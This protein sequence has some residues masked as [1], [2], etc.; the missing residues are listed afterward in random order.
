MQ[1][2]LY[3][4]DRP[5]TFAFAARLRS[6]TEQKPG[7]FLLAELASD[8]PESAIADYTAGNDRFHTAYSF[9]FLSKPFGP[10]VIRKGVE[11]LFARAPDA[12]PSWAFSNH[13]FDRVASRW[14]EGRGPDFAKSLIML[15]T[16]LPGTIF[17]YQGEELGL[18]QAEVPFEALRDP[19][20]IAFWPAYKGRDGE[21]TPIPWSESAPHGGFSDADPW[22]PIDPRHL[23]MAVDRQEADPHSTLTFTRDWLSFRRSRPVFTLPGIVFDDEAPGGVLGFS[24]GHGAL[25]LVF[26][27]GADAVEIP[28]QGARIVFGL[29]ATAANETIRLPAGAA[30][31]LEP[32]RETA[33]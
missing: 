21:R 16:S 15:L 1:R 20:G 26:N 24:R 13:D 11:D 25:R 8:D 18:P 2:H 12:W 32:S 17:L 31:A 29:S 5:E 28:A 7:R 30:A 27:L 6:L 10:E 33:I 9:R 3:D 22:L 14:G 23:A 4:R 19:D